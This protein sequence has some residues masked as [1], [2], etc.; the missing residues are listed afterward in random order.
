MKNSLVM[1]GLLVTA[2]ACQGDPGNVDWDQSV[3]SV[4]LATAAA[5]GSDASG[6]GPWSQCSVE[7]KADTLGV[8][9]FRPGQQGTYS[10]PPQGSLI[11][12]L[13]VKSAQNTALQVAS[14]PESPI[15]IEQAG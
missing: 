1:A 13:H 10:S 6:V 9:F 4:T 2:S 3:C 12:T 5:T 8:V 11:I 15:P 14:Q 7:L